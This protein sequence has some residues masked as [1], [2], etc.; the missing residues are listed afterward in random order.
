MY[1]DKE[2][3]RDVWKAYHAWLKEYRHIPG[4]YGL[5]VNMPIV[6]QAIVQGTE[7]GGNMLGLE[8]AGNR[9]LGGMCFYPFP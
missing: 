4:L 8:S 7:K 3:Y 6:P 2:L 1:A 5:H 9:T